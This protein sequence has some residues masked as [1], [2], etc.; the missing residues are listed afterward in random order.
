MCIIVSMCA[1]YAKDNERIRAK[2]RKLL[3]DSA[4]V[5]FARLGVHAGSIAQI[6]KEAGVSKGL[7]YH[8]FSS[9][10]ELLAELAAARLDEWNG[11][12]EG[13]ERLEDPFQRLKFLVDFIL[14]ELQEKTDWL[15]FFTGLYLTADGRGAISKVMEVHQ[16]RFDRLFAL[17]KRLLR[18]LGVRDVETEQVYLR[19]TL[20][21]ICLEYMLSEDYPL[22]SMRGRLIQTYKRGISI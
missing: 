20:Q 2:T 7:A 18:D 22:N 8:Y 9:K 17:E 21:G 4:L 5:V 13:L 14:D 3:L 12:V 16:E 19:S 1:R 11:L 15:R 6:A 10:E